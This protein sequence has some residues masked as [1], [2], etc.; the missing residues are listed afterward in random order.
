DVLL[1][2]QPKVNGERGKHPANRAPQ[3][4]A[5]KLGLGRRQVVVREGAE[6]RARWQAKARVRGKRDEEPP[7]GPLR[8]KDEEH[9]S[10]A[11]EENCQEPFHW[12]PTIRKE[13]PK[14]RQEAA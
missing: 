9:G 7:K 6:E 8:G 4:Q 14:Q 11:R 10:S 3:P 1:E 12:T 5:A 2:S 13:A